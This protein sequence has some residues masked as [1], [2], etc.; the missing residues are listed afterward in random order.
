MS[1]AFFIYRFMQIADE[2]KFIDHSLYDDV[3]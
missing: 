2:Y 1:K 3:L